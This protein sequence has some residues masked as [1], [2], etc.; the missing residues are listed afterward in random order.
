MRQQEVLAAVRGAVNRSRLLDTAVKLVEVPSP[1]CDAGA[2]SDRLDELLTAEG[3]RVERPVANW[4]K[5][6]AVV[7]RLTSGRPGRTLEFNG[8][9]DTVHLPFVPPRVESGVLRGSGASD[10]KGGIAAA[11]E[12]MRAIRDTGLLS[13]GGILFAAHDLHEGPWGDCRQLYALIDEGIVGDGVLL[14]EY[15]CDRLAVVGRGLAI[16]EIRV[17]RDGEPVHEVW[18]PP[19]QPDVIAAACEVVTRLKAL[20]RDLARRPHPLAGPA[21]AFVGQ[22][23]GGEIYNQSPT[24]C[25]IYGTR[26][27]LPGESVAEIGRQYQAMLSEVAEATGTR[28]SSDFVMRRDAFEMDPATPLVEAFQASHQAI[29]GARLPLGAK[30]FVDDGNAFAAR[31]GIPA[32]THGPLARGAHTLDERVSVDELVRV[33]ELYALTALT[34]CPA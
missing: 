2:V 29:S 25:W 17:D 34:F 11:I 7:T 16:L 13:G 4:P 22:I 6:P 27:W 12:A 15:L 30:P 20:D 24:E 31:A 5:A 14:P 1:T 19:G 9:L 21:S 3:F 28:V 26:R 23:R 10:M 18:R 33:A 32:I 8:H